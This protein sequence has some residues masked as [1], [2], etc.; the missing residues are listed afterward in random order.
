M[1]FSWIIYGAIST[2]V[3]I[4][5]DQLPFILFDMQCVFFCLLSVAL[6]LC[7]DYYFDN[8]L[9]NLIFVLFR[10]HRTMVKAV[11]VLSSSEGVKG[12]VYFAQ[13]GDGN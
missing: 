5:L 10:S 12:T 3:M 8:T 11:A 9:A 6:L 4:S 13:E 1:I 7:G 2:S